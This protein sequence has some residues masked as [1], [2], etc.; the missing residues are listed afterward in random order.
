MFLLGWY[1][2]FLVAIAE[3]LTASGYWP[4]A[5]PILIVLAILFV[6]SWSK[7]GATSR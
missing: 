6:L 7:S 2:I 1:G 5:I 3:L 4:L